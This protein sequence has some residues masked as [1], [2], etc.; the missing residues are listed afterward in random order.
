MIPLYFKTIDLTI[1][2][3]ITRVSSGNYGREITRTLVVSSSNRSAALSKKI[4]TLPIRQIDI[5]QRG[6]KL[7]AGDFFF[8]NQSG[9]SLFFSTFR[10]GDIRG[11]IALKIVRLSLRTISNAVQYL[12]YKCKRRLRLWPTVIKSAE[13]VFSYVAA[14][15][16]CNI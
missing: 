15:A 10:F 3:A 4:R 14:S 6:E 13:C 1:F 16:V 7:K 5:K 2:E 11:R 8:S 12:V 9:C